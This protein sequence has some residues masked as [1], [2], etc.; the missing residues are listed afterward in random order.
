MNNNFI[1]K[2]VVLVFMLS[3]MFHYWFASN[4]AIAADDN[5]ELEKTY[6]NVVQSHLFQ[7]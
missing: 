2:A 1:K 4:H 6:M 5:Q 7:V 3:M